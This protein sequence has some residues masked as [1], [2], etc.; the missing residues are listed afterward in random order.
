MLVSVLAPACDTGWAIWNSLQRRLHH[1]AL[2]SLWGAHTHMLRVGCEVGLFRD[3][4]QVLR[5]HDSSDPPPRVGVSGTFAS[6]SC[7]SPLLVFF[8]HLCG[9]PG[10]EL[11]NRQGQDPGP[12]EESAELG[13]GMVGCSS[14]APNLHC[15][16]CRAW[17]WWIE[18]G[19][20]NI[21]FSI[22]GYSSVGRVF[23]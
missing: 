1:C 16:V 9:I 15:S 7:G 5:G 4:E 23:A 17:C 14:S 21:Q 18:R 8:S 19:L 2:L 20:I 10:Q 12:R 11:D 13:P 22:W 6:A 3:M